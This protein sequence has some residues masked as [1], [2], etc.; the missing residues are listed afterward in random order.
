MVS[1]KNNVLIPYKWFKAI[2]ILPTYPWLDN[3]NHD[4]D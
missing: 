3:L 1:T 4:D 2:E